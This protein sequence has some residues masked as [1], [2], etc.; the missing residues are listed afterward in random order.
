MV[1]TLFELEGICPLTTAEALRRAAVL[2]PDLEAVVAPDG[3]ATFGQI[4]EEVVH[5]RSALKGTGI[6]HGDRV[7]FRSIAIKPLDGPGE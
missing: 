1:E 5:I 6:G 7:D 4:A 3:R 2:A